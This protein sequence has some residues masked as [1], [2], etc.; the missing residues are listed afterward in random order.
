MRDAYNA[1]TKRSANIARS[2]MLAFHQVCRITRE[3]DIVDSGLF[4]A[5]GFNNALDDSGLRIRPY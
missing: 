1:Y 3:K 4:F 5:I 2:R